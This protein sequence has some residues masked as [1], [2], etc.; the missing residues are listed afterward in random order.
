MLTGAELLFQCIPGIY[1]RPLLKEILKQIDVTEE[2][3]IKLL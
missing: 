2:E 3:I 1:P